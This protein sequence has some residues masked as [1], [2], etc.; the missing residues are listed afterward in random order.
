MVDLNDTQI[1]CTQ[2]KPA[3]GAQLELV[4]GKD[5]LSFKAATNQLAEEWH[6]ALDLLSTPMDGT[7]V[8]TASDELD[9]PSPAPK[10]IDGGA[11]AAVAAAAEPAEEKATEAPPTEAPPAEKATEAPPVVP[12]FSFKEF[13][14]SFGRQNIDALMKYYTSSSIVTVHLLN[15]GSLHQH[16]G[17]VNIRAFIEGRFQYLKDLSELTAPL[18][19]V[20]KDAVLAC[21]RCPSSG[22]DLAVESLVLSLETGTIAKHTIVMSQEHGLDGPESPA[23]PSVT[24]QLQS[25]WDAYFQ[26]FGEKDMNRII[27]SYSST[28]RT[29]T[30]NVSEDQAQVLEGPEGARSLFNKQ[31]ASLAGNGAIDTVALSL[32][33]APLGTAFLVWRC[34]ESGVISS[35]NTFLFDSQGKIATHH[36]CTTYAA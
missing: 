33:E 1:E 26:A 32:G 8:V 34:P 36:A 6:T 22:V 25:S 9:D 24:G 14:N 18:V 29:T 13:F 10:S 19:H 4:V 3:K 11:T 31:F 27:S 5:T 28:A 12:E 21:W 30:W 35:I 17:L 16:E 15:S 23:S 7:D 2:V 20:E